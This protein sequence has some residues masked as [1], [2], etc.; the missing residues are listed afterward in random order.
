M[1]FDRLTVPSE[2]EGLMAGLLN[3]LDATIHLSV[4]Q[5]CERREL[6]II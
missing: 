2:V 3:L 1:P 4:D 6:I 5:K